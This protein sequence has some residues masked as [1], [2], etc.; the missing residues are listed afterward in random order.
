MAIRKHHYA[1]RC[2]DCVRQ[3]NARRRRDAARYAADGNPLPSGA[4]W[5]EIETPGG[6]PVRYEDERGIDGLSQGGEQT[7]AR[8]EAAPETDSSPPDAVD[9]DD[10][11]DREQSA[12]ENERPTSPTQQRD[13]LD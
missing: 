6:H 8:G 3:R 13:D 10:A 9:K 7:Q 4:M 12:H 11:Q 1:C 5:Y 2:N